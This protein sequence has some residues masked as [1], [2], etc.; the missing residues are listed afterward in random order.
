[1]NQTVETY[2]RYCI[3]YNQKNKIQLLLMT[4]IVLNN[5]KVSVT[6]KSVF[7]TNYE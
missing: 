4:Q 1:M 3:N 2:L 6:E 7:Y 5:R